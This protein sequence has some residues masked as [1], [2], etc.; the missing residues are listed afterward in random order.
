MKNR[1]WS[2]RRFNV[3]LRALEA[4]SGPLGLGVRLFFWRPEPDLW[5]VNLEIMTPIFDLQ[6]GFHRKDAEL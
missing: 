4:R 6:V 3:A 1:R 5:V 2:G